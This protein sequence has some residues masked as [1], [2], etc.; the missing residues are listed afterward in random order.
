MTTNDFLPKRNVLSMWDTKWK[1]Y[2]VLFSFSKECITHR[3]M[4][5]ITKR[6]NDD[7][8]IDENDENISRQKTEKP[9]LFS[10]LE[11]SVIRY[12][13]IEVA[14][15]SMLCWMRYWFWF[16]PTRFLFF[17]C[18]TFDAA[19][20]QANKFT[21]LEYSFRRIAFEQTTGYIFARIRVLAYRWMSFAF[22]VSL[23][24]I[25]A[26]NKFI[27]PMDW[28]HSLRQRRFG[29]GGWRFGGR[30]SFLKLRQMFLNGFQALL[31]R[32]VEENR[33]NKVA[34]WFIA[35]IPEKQLIKSLFIVVLMRNKP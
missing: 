11:L 31:N 30:R 29:W 13:R 20:K 19:C 4:N 5:S 35:K 26:M 32:S 16:A 21:S 8:G 18:V 1:H 2:F 14:W 34:I 12:S 24:F 28:M 3:K 25:L 15:L 27:F 7:D 9:K 23:G 17:G 22:Q 10:V 33:H 6:M